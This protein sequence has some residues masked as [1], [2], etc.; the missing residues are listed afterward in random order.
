MRT[1][2]IG[3]IR[4]SDKPNVKVKFDSKLTKN[5]RMA[6][7][8]HLPFPVGK[9]KWI[10][11]GNTELR[12]DGRKNGIVVTKILKTKPYRQYQGLDVIYT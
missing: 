9:I 5:D 3:A 10:S 8:K 4:S 2:S 11:H 6:I 1:P 12:L 7:K